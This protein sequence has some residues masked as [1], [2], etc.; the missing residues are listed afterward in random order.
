MFIEKFL[1]YTFN[2]ITEVSTVLNLEFKNIVF[3]QPNKPS[4]FPDG[5]PFRLP[6]STQEKHFDPLMYQKMTVGVRPKVMAKA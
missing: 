2:P 6:R 5:N 1:L 3:L 4:T